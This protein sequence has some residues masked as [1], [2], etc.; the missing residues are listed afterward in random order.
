LFTHGVPAALLLPLAA[1][2]SPAA[3]A[4]S[5][6]TLAGRLMMA[7]YVA[8]RRLRDPVARRALWLVPLRDLLGFALW[9][10]AYLGTT[11]VWRGQRFRLGE[12]GK[13]SPSQPAAP[14]GA[15]EAIATTRAVS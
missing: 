1:A 2:G 9:I 7:W 12:D 15:G 13:L 11:I 14:A 10:A 8:V 4:L 6:A 5:A 3:W